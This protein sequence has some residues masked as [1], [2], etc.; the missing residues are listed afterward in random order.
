MLIRLYP[1]QAAKHWK[2][3]REAIAESLPKEEDDSSERYN[4][5]LNLILLDRLVCWV[6]LNGEKNINGI[7][8]TIIETDFINEKNNVL[9]YTMTSTGVIDNRNW[10]EAYKTLSDY[11]RSMNCKSFIFYTSDQAAIDKASRMG[12]ITE[13]RIVKLPLYKET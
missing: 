13:R 9:L 2:E 7:F 8:T 3:L 4:N 1:E 5:L 12:A 11:A 6:S 10:I